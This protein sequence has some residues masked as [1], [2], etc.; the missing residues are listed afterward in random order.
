MSMTW[1]TCSPVHGAKAMSNID[2]SYREVLKTLRSPSQSEWRLMNSL[3][4]RRLINRQANALECLKH[5][6]RKDEFAERAVRLNRGTASR[7]LVLPQGVKRKSKSLWARR[8]SRQNRHRQQQIREKANSTTTPPSSNPSSPKYRWTNP[9]PKAQQEKDNSSRNSKTG[10][11]FVENRKPS[12]TKLPSNT[13]LQC[14]VAPFVEIP[15][16]PVF[17]DESKVLAKM[18][19]SKNVPFGS[20]HH[21]HRHLSA[22]R[23]QRFLRNALL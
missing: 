16:A 2:D 10:L 8:R 12:T 13:I 14:S 15:K 17:F 21:I 20:E 19:A 18:K 4:R 11:L 6:I 22:K 1:T 5:I 7:S 3:D 9:E 23:I